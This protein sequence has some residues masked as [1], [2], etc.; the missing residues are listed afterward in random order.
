MREA[1]AALLTVPQSSS[2]RNM[3]EQLTEAARNNSPSYKVP[4]AW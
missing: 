1:I 2:L 4:A 3:P